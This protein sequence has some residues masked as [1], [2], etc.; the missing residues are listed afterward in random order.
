MVGAFVLLPYLL[1]LALPNPDL[2]LER[3]LQYA[4][5]G[6]IFICAGFLKDKQRQKLIYCVV[7]SGIIIAILAIYQ[8]FFGF[9][10]TQEYMAGKNIINHFA[11]DSLGTR[12]VFLPFVTANILGAYLAMVILIAAG[13]KK[14]AYLCLILF[15]ALL[16]TGSISALV[17][18]CAGLA[19]F[20]VLTAK[21]NKKWLLYLGAIAISI[22]AVFLFR[23]LYLK[24]HFSP[25]FSAQMRLEYW[26][27]T[28]QIIQRSPAFGIGSGNFNLAHSRFAHQ[29]YL[30]LW[31]ESGILSLTAFL[32][33]VF[34]V[35]FYGAKRIK[36]HNPQASALMGAYLVFLIDNLFSFS[37]FLPEI[38][39]IWWAVGG[40]ILSLS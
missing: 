22:A 24:Q 38:S 7:F 34:S 16:L 13:L 11:S 28:W 2:G 25:G 8:Y 6:L 5:S 10:H 18:I 3:I 17:S 26:E 37:F 23:M 32:C 30:Q 40:A 33:L 20:F 29:S 4:A 12:R 1:M 14:R 15:F 36:T 21:M 31:A 19:L 9:S 35:F 27:Q 39:W